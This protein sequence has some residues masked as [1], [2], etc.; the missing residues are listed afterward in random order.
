MASGAAGLLLSYHL[1][2]AGRAGDHPRRGFRLSRLAGVFGKEGGLVWLAFRGGGIWRR[3]RGGGRVVA[4]PTPPRRGDRRLEEPTGGGER[5]VANPGSPS[6]VRPSRPTSRAGETTG[7][8]D[9]QGLLQKGSLMLDRR[10]VVTLLCAAGMMTVLAAPGRAE[11]PLPAVA[12]FSILGDLVAK[13]GRR[14]GGPVTTLGGAGRGRA[15][16]FADAGGRPA[17][18]GSPRRVRQWAR[19]RGLDRSPDR[20]LTARRPRSSSPATAST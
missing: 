8:R 4:T 19:V 6:P 17:R 7:L 3:D 5:G 10:N 18:L 16:L 12:T 14:P 1:R 9:C 11:A 13:R 20:V 15:R 2:A